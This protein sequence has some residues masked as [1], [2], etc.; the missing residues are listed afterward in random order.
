LKAL[1]CQENEKW[2]L[3]KNKKEKKRIKINPLK[4]DKTNLL[5][6]PIPKVSYLKSISTGAWCDY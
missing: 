2:R 4:R 3:N 6:K 5:F 1:S